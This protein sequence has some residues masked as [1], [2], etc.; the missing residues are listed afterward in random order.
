MAQ[1]TARP[2]QRRKEERPGEILEAAFDEFTRHGFAATRLDAVAARAGITKGTIYIYF[3]SKEDL[4]VAAVSER[5]RPVNEHMAALSANP[6][7]SAMAILRRHFEFVYAHMVHERGG[8][9]LIRMVVAE[10]GRFPDI[11][12]RWHD[13]VIGPSV[14]MLR[15]VVRYGVGRGEFRASA[16]EE[17]PHLLF[18]P[19]MMAATWCSLFGAVRP[20]DLD[21]YRAA[22]LDL[23]EQSLR[24][25]PERPPD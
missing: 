13:A 14:E 18:S 24:A 4:F 9:D 25:S 15:R 12:E 8:R 6:Q 3:P 20:L 19:V 23:M 11:A 17:F 10:A 22:H 5:V 1:G 2:R 21:R 7:G 16:A